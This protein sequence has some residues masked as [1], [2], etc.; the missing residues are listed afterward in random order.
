[1]L[2]IPVMQQHDLVM[3]T[4]FFL[5]ILFSIMVYHRIFF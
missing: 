1:M 5:K 2:F 3:H 4:F